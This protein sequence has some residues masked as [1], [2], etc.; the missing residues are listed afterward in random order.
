MGED[1]NDLLVASFSFSLRAVAASA[2][3]DA[4]LSFSMSFSRFCRAERAAARLAFCV[5]PSASRSATI[6]NV[7]SFSCTATDAD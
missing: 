7:R 2:S 6:R 1:D 5:F 3:T 4:T